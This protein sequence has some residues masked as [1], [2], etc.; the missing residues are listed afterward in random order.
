MFLQRKLKQADLVSLQVLFPQHVWE[1]MRENSKRRKI[2]LDLL[3]I[4]AVSGY[5][6]RCEDKEKGVLA[7]DI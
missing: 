2:P 3:I 7:Y 5:L 4:S 6:I 1:R